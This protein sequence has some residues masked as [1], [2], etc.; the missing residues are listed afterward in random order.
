MAMASYLYTNYR[1]P[2]VAGLAAMIKTKM[3]IWS[4]KN[5]PNENIGDGL[6]DS[7]RNLNRLGPWT[8]C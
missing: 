5:Y 2:R 6:R 7:N 3:A 1:N 8:V 4:F